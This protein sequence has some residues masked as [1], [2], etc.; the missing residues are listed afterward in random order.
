M[1]QN[2]LDILVFWGQSLW[3]FFT[4]WKIPGT[5]VTPA[6][7]LLFLVFAPLVFKYIFKIFDI[8][9]K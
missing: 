3:Q 2:G 9:G 8:G 4:A 1:T 5:G 6:G 7:W